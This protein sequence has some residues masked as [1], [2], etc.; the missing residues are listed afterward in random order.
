[1]W[2]CWRSADM[3]LAI[4]Y[5]INVVS[6][7]C[8]HRLGVLPCC[9]DTNAAH[10][11]SDKGLLVLAQYPCDV[12]LMLFADTSLERETLLSACRGVCYHMG[13]C[14]FYIQHA[15][16]NQ[17][18]KSIHNVSVRPNHLRYGRRGLFLFETRVIAAM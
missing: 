1:M 6:S 4:I 11:R 13:C 9:E 8:Q 3:E 2:E 10:G 14:P 17:H 16:S 15:K 12:S 5:A 7:C 18:D